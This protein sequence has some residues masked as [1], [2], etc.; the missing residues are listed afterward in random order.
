MKFSIIYF[1]YIHNR[2]F[3][4]LGKTVESLIMDLEYEG[5]YRSWPFLKS[6]LV[7]DRQTFP[8]L[9]STFSHFVALEVY[10]VLHFIPI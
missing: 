3:E 4:I 9:T 5:I 7:I 1:R 8:L 6:D 10:S 2:S